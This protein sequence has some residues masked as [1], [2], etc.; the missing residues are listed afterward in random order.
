MKNSS[1]L[2]LTIMRFL[3]LL[4]LLPFSSFTQKLD[5]SRYTSV[6]VKAVKE[7][8]HGLAT[9]EARLI[10]ECTP[11]PPSTTGEMT[12]V[13]PKNNDVIRSGRSAYILAYLINYSPDT[14][15]IDR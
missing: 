11:F 15:Q 12:V 8:P 3:L 10:G 2:H 14:I 6:W 7:D 1:C 9:D 13:I 4:L 5:F